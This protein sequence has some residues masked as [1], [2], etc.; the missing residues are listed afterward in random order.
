MLHVLIVSRLHNV[1]LTRE[2]E[3][4]VKAVSRPPPSSQLIFHVCLVAE[5][6]GGA[7]VD[8]LINEYLERMKREDEVDGELIR[9][10]YVPACV[11]NVGG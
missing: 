10:T 11:L 7:P 2:S 8:D 1:R 6:G 5:V 3:P 9:G 4:K